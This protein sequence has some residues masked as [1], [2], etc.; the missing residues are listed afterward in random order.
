[1]A[2][3]IGRSGWQPATIAVGNRIIGPGLM[4]E[5]R[6]QA[7]LAPGR[8]PPADGVPCPMGKEF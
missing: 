7:M 4:A 1:M 8:R 3:G 2:A 5:S 6:R